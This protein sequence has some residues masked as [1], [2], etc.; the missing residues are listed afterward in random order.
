MYVA[1][2]FLLA[3]LTVEYANP[4]WAVLTV[5]FAVAVHFLTVRREEAYLDR[6]FGEDYR[7]YRESVR[8]WL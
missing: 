8:R 4:W 6:L 1:L 3:G 7:S 5:A 2:V